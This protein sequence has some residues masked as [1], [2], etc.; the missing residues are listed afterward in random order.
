M[1]K[2][3]IRSLVPVWVLLM[4]PMTASALEAGECE[5]DVDCEGG[6]VCQKAQWVEGCAA[7]DPADPVSADDAGD[8]ESPPPVD[9]DKGAGSDDAGD[10]GEPRPLP[11]ECDTTVHEEE[12]GRCV[13]P[14]TPCSEDSEC[15]EYER[16]NLVSGGSTCGVSEDG[17]SDGSSEDGSPPPGDCQ[18][19]PESASATGTCGPG[20]FACEVSEDCPREFECV[21]TSG[22]GDDGC[23]CVTEPCDCGS[24]A[25]ERKSCVPKT[26]ECDSDAECPDDWACQGTES[27]TCSGSGG[28]SDGSTDG[29]SDPSEG[30]PTPTSDDGGVSDDSGDGSSDGSSDG[31]P[32]DRTTECTTVKRKGACLPKAWS[33]YGAS[34]GAGEPREDGELNGGDDLSS[35]EGDDGTPPPDKDGNDPG[36]GSPVSQDGEG[37]AEESGDA[38]VSKGGCSVG[39]RMTSPSPGIWAIGIALMG[40]LVRRRRRAA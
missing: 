32:P 27:V 10:S 23:A 6:A 11:P 5:S 9:G 37:A 31:P 30:V 1:M 33:S 7:P 22:G 4:V 13:V 17:A 38:S 36:Q 16:C 12:I 24:S 26:V 20:N 19:A 14:P 18:E 21:V 25:E 2:M 40:V 39:P 34:Q 8:G 3:K 35:N 15:G 29:G 28:S